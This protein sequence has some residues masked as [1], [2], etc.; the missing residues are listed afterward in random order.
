MLN[1]NKT[2]SLKS[3][4]SSSILSA[5]ILYS[6][7][8]VRDLT[9][10]SNLYL[11]DI[12]NTPIGSSEHTSK[13]ISTRIRSYEDLSTALTNHI[14]RSTSDPTFSDSL[15]LESLSIPIRSNN[16]NSLSHLIQSQCNRSLNSTSTN[17]LFGPPH[18]LGTL[19]DSHHNVTNNSNTNQISLPTNTSP[20]NR[21]KHQ[22]FTNDDSSPDITQ[23]ALSFQR[24]SLNL[25]SVDNILRTMSRPRRHT[26]STSSTTSSLSDAWSLTKLNSYDPNQ[27]QR[28]MQHLT[29]NKIIKLIRKRI[30]TD[31]LTKIPDQITSRMIQKER[32]YQKRIESLREHER[33]M[34]KFVYTLININ[35]N[36][37]YI[38]IFK[39]KAC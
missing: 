23:L 25:H 8:S 1:S 11:R 27:T 19:N 33:Q 20:D 14:H 24:F 2:I 16:Y 39:K 7:S 29:S 12:R 36:Q 22:S 28:M 6:S 31:G 30:D 21:I 9:I 35:H 4:L 17:S 15:P 13:T 34:Q 5:H 18:H 10:W 26:N 37:V 3:S 38:H 32:S